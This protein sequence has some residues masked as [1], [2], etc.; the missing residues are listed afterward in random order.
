[1]SAATI[2]SN[3]LN[4]LFENQNKLDDLFDSIFD[5]GSYFISSVSSS[6]SENLYLTSSTPRSI[7]PKQSRVRE[8]L[9]TIKERCPYFF[10]LPIMLEI[11]AI[12]FVASSLL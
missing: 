6:Q 4:S 9:L 10:I 7:T 12:Y 5:D 1:M 8:S 2:D 3:V 11:A